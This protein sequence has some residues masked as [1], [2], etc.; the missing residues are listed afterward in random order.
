LDAGS[1]IG[2]SMVFS[3]L[4]ERFVAKK[5]VTVM[6]RATMEHALAPE[7]LDALFMDRAEQQ[8]TRELLFSSIVDLMGMVV[9]KIQPSIHAAY[10]EVAETLPVALTSVYNKINGVE[11]GVTAAL[12]KHTADRLGAVVT[13]MGGEAVDLLPGYRVRIIDGNHLA[14]TERRVKV[15]RRSKAGPLPGQAL[16]V[17]D[18]RLMLATE[19]IPCEDG[20]AQERSLTPEIL[21]IV[22]DRDVWIADRNFCTTALLGGIA[23]RGAYFVVRQHAAL[24][25]HA[26]GPLR[27]CGPAET[28]EV[29][30]QAVTIDLGG[31]RL[32]DARRVVVR[33]D[34]KTRDGDA[35]IA[36]LTNLPSDA[37]DAATL[38]ET[39]RDRWTLENVFQALTM[40]FDGELD[41][42]GYPRAALLG[43]AVALAAY[44]VLSAVQAALR[45]TFGTEK[46]QQEVS[47]FYIAN[48]VRITHG[49]MT[50]ALEPEEWTPFQTMTSGAFAK[51]LLRI[52]KHVNLRVFKRHPRGPKKPVPKRTKFADRPHVSTARLLAEARKRRP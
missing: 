4:F 10:Q 1:G 34:K 32:L 26:I 52:A 43:F 45:G 24:P 15:I 25:V 30:E 19:M 50:I 23:E 36:I 42:L 5:P 13:Q 20:H 6:A 3:Q 35:E 27:S 48:E 33:L 18:P 38:A 22:A 44:N 40:M 12:V 39:Y 11:P 8:Y 29:F 21:R 17:L 28:G 49:G 47:G 41:T 7:A 37:A 9:A 31:G 2:K 16:V 51:T 46:V 14:A